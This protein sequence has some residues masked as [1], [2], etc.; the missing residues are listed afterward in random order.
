MKKRYL[1]PTIELIDIFSDK[2]CVELGSNE[3]SETNTLNVFNLK[4][5]E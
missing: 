2:Y 1:A 5:D 3:L 4:E